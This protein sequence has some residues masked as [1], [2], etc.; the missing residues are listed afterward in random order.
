MRN[1]SKY[2]LK[3]D[4]GIKKKRFMQK[5]D[6]LCTQDKNNFI[7]DTQGEQALQFRPR[8]DST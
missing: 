1:L 7:N 2:C 4:C 8:M 3:Q 5:I 6:Y